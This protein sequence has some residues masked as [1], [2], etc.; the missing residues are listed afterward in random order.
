MNSQYQSYTQRLVAFAL[1]RLSMYRSAGGNATCTHLYRIV[2][3]VVV[4]HDDLGL[5]Q[6]GAKV[7]HDFADRCRFVLQSPALLRILDQRRK[8]QD[9]R[10][11]LH[12]CDCEASER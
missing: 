2:P 11:D 10:N 1:Q 12:D 6:R 9:H 7:A 3:G 4:V 5:G 8:L